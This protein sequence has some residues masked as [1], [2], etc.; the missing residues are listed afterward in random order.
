MYYKIISKKIVTKLIPLD[1]INENDRE[2]YEYCFEILIST[3][4]IILTVIAIGA[5]V[6]KILC[7]ILFLASFILTRRFCGGYHAK[8]HFTCWLTTI[9]NQ[10]IF[11]VLLFICPE[12]FVFLAIIILNILSLILIFWLSPI[13]NEHNPLT[14][15]EIKC[16]RRRSII[17]ILLCTVFNAVSFFF[18]NSYSFYI[19]SINFG[20]FS[21]SF[22]LLVAKIESDIKNKKNK[23][24][25]S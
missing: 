18:L 20:I 4:V 8:H 22:S 15:E 5:I 1:A 6:N 24:V 19:F 11:L 25:S 12:N 2:I 9:F 16:H 10:S 14:D 7:S 13:E 17:L 23:E 21:V 3:A